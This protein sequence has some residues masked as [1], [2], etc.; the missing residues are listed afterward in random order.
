[1]LVRV[2]LGFLGGQVTV[3]TED[4]LYVPVHCEAAR[5]DTGIVVPIEI[6]AVVLLASPI[7]RNVVILLEDRR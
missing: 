3:P 4:V 7:L 1:M 5:A 2:Q 6:N